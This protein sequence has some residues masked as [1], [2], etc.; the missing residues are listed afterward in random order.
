HQEPIAWAKIPREQF[1]FV[2]V[3]ATEGAD[4][5]D[6]SFQRHWHEAKAAGLKVGAYHYFKI[7]KGGIEQ[8][9]NFAATVP[10]EPGMIA[11][12]I[13]L[14]DKGC[15][16]K[17]AETQVL[18]EIERFI[19][20]IAAVYGKRPILYTTY[21]FAAD[22][23]PDDMITR[24]QIWIRDTFSKPRGPFARHWIL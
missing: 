19:G 15:A 16:K 17:P 22:H 12:V 4:L 23:L 7:C 2:I 13:D 11:P 8:A 1:S 14:E 10:V 6:P 3:K 20:T 18:Q 5:V 9:K 21:K 24:E